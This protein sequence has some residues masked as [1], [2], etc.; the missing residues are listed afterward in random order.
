[1]LV[2][3]ANFTIDHRVEFQI[4]NNYFALIS[5]HIM[6]RI[7]IFGTLLLI[8]LFCETNLPPIPVVIEGIKDSQPLDADTVLWNKDKTAIGKVELCT[9]HVYVLCVHTHAFW[10]LKW[11]LLS[12]LQH[13]R[14][15]VHCSLVAA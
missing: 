14:T 11:G 1:M 15:Y 12:R 7:L 3:F 9:L 10:G 8:V 5:F 6:T 13:V 2:Y 4:H